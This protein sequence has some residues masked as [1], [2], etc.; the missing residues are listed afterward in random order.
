[1]KTKTISLIAV[2]AIASGLSAA[3][4]A[5]KRHHDESR[6]ESRHE[7]RAE[8]IAEHLTEKLSLSDAQ[9]ER[10]EEMLRETFAERAALRKS[11]KEQIR[12][13]VAQDALSKEDALRILN[14]RREMREE[15]QNKMAERL[16]AF[17]AILSPEQRVIMSEIHPFGGM[18]KRRG[19][20]GGWHSDRE[21]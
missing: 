17:H 16:V 15:R 12:A 7:H 19:K 14:I 13:L 3:V 20:R 10:L 5:G 8:H 11:V 2:V 6:H 9:D 1:M 21:E 18:E 4:Y